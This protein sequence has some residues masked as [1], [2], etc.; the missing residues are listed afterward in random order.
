MIAS[1]QAVAERRAP[2]VFTWTVRPGCLPG[3]VRKVFSSSD[4]KMPSTIGIQTV[5]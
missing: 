1:I 3:P 2:W 4:L 5:T